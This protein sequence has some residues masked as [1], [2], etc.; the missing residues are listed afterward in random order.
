M[1]RLK[2]SVEEKR[3]RNREYQQKRREKINSDPE[4][5]R[6]TKEREKQRWKKR[7]ED[8]KVTQIGTMGNRA[9]RNKR[10]YWREAQKRSRQK[11][12]SEG[13]VLQT[14]TPPDSPQDMNGQEDNARQRQLIRLERERSKTR[15]RN[16]RKIQT[17][18][19]K[20]HKLRKQ[21]NKLRKQI[22]REKTAANKT[23]LDSPRKE[24]KMMLSGSTIRNP[25]IKKALLFHNILKRELKNNKQTPGPRCQEPALVL[26]GKILKK[27][28]L[29]HQIHQF[30]LTYKLMR[31]KKQTKKKPTFLQGMTQTVQDFFRNCARMTTDKT[32]TITRNKIKHQRMILT[33]SLINLHTDF[34]TRNPTVK[35]SYSS[36]CALRPFY[37]TA[38]KTS[39]RKT[40]LCQMHENA[41]L[42]LEVLRSRGVVKSNKLEDSFQL[43]CCSPASEACLLRTC[44]RCVNKSTIPSQEQDKIQVQWKQWERVEENTA[45]GSHIN[46]KLVQHSGSLSKLI[47]LYEQKLIKETTTHVCL[48]L[49]Q[50]NAYRNTIETCDECTAIVHVDFSESWRC[51]YQS[52]VQACHFGQNLPQITLH[53]GMYY[54]KGEKAGFCTVSESKRQDAS[55]IWTH[56]DP[57]LKTIKTKYPHITTVHVWSDGPSKQYKNKKNFYFLSG[58]PSTLGFEKVTWNFFPT[59]H[60]KG[61]PDGIGGTVKRTADNLVLRGN[62]LTDGKTFLEKVSNCLRGIQLHYITEEDM[63]IYDALLIQPLKQVP[64]TRQIHQ[65]IAQENRIQHRQLSCF[66][67]QMLVCLCFS[68]TTFFFHDYP[69][70]PQSHKRRAKKRPLAALIEEMEKE[71]SEGIEEEWDEELL[72]GPEGTIKVTTVG[73][74]HE[75]D[76]LAVV[77]DNH[78][79]LA[80]TIAV[81]L[82]H[83][84]VEVEFLH[85]HGPTEKVKPKHGRKDVCFCPV[86]DIIVKLMGKASPVQSRTREIYNIVPDVMDF[87]DRE[88]ARRLLLT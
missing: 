87:I 21:R 6:A 61:A 48:V 17:L 76:W 75:G 63:Q 7:V 47:K 70:E 29:L 37:V 59:S 34:L 15:K 51:K 13:A 73:G 83:Q 8:K 69:E 67:S 20:I 41:C 26:S 3:Q 28:R 55:A 82:E 62:D 57:V 11:R 22:W 35:L 77:Y 86:K 50:S 12:S 71:D 79:W 5:K 30:G 38:P 80:K 46:I 64:L 60:G 72:K 45:N 18:K 33:D 40:C 19:E 10:K 54:I 58:I 42:M 66:C 52:E 24:T 23:P 39:D 36:F 84:D 78:W 2:L 14:D 88:H 53:T 43:V 74:L 85:P 31:E 4:K 1:A 44:S 9:K 81:D 49:N 65:V 27:Y 16:S 32:D 56:M 25:K 68:P